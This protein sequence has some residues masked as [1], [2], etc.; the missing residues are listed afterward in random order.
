MPVRNFIIGSTVLLT[1]L[2]VLFLCGCG[3]KDKTDVEVKQLAPAKAKPAEDLGAVKTAKK[4]EELKKK[5][6]DQE[7]KSPVFE[8]KNWE[9]DIQ[10]PEV[11]DN[12]KNIE[13]DEKD[14]EDGSAADEKTKS[15]KLETPKDSLAGRTI[16]GNVKIKWSP[17]WIYQGVGGVNLPDVALS[18]DQSVLAIM[19]TI[20]EP[21]GPN[22][23]R[24]ILFD[25]YSW[26][27]LRLHE[28]KDCKFSMMRFIGSGDTLAVWEE[29]QQD[30]KK[31]FAIVIVKTDDGKIIA[32]TNAL[33]K[34]VS[35]IA[36]A[37]DSLF[38]KPTGDGPEDVQVFNISDL[39][40]APSSAKSRNAGGVFAVSND[41]STV[42][43]AGEA[44]V[45]IFDAEG[46]PRDSI[47]LD[48][49]KDYQ[50]SSATFAG[51]NDCVAIV[52]N[53]KPSYL[54]K[55]GKAKMISEISGRAVICSDKNDCII[56]GSPKNDRVVF[57]GLPELNEK[58]AITPSSALPRT[59]GQAV[60]I[61]FL[62]HHGR[63]AVLDTSGNLCLYLKSGKRWKKQL[64]FSAQ[65]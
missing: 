34:P 45:E 43:L 48:A 1:C 62:K 28:F 37:G 9:G 59:T 35:G 20:G 29:K 27:I 47:R 13:F 17:Q 55:G 2:T 40:S 36:V 64:I 54:I 50:V 18:E 51:R 63:Y 3:K 11:K 41:R 39:N 23:T 4:D 42:V 15:V 49:G 16:P 52:S 30:L 33:K 5:E 60:M 14:E 24:I 53:L 25:T 65:K 8:L 10:K 56:A 58:D 31:P 61:A 19:E 21:K 38:V 6:G 46:N 22:G 32:S 12:S 26:E 57:Y 44:Y 7:F